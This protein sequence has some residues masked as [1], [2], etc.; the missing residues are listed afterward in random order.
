MPDQAPIACS[1][2]AAELPGRLAEMAALGA[3]ALDTVEENG[4]QTRLRFRASPGVRE[5]LAGIVAAEAHCC[6]F[7]GMT[8][9]DEPGLVVLTVEAPAGAEPVV[10][11]MVAAFSGGGL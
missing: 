8:L 5:R 4:R 3:G 10:A 2:T 1:L 6:A 11:E 7:L 9:R